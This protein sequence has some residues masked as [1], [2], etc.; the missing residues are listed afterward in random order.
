MAAPIRYDDDD[1]DDDDGDDDIQ[2]DNIV[3]L[4]FEI[5]M[6]LA[7]MKK[8]PYRGQLSY[9]MDGWM[10]VAVDW[11]HYKTITVTDPKLLSLQSL[12]LKP[13][14][15]SFSFVQQQ[16]QQHNHD[17]D[18]NHQSAWPSCRDRKPRWGIYLSGSH[19]KPLTGNDEMYVCV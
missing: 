11:A 18:H 13:A 2:F 17:F 6:N 8:R 1:Y 12:P 16:Q 4:K 15:L 3:E 14:T 5:R 9:R 7:Q 10:G 19:F